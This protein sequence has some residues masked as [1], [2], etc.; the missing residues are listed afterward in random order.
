MGVSVHVQWKIGPK[1]A[2][3]VVKSRKF[4]PL[5]GQ[6]QSLN[7]TILLVLH[8]EFIF[9]S[10][11]YSCDWY[12]HRIFIRCAYQSR[13]RSICAIRP[14]RPTPTPRISPVRVT[15][16]RGPSRVIGSRGLS[17]RDT[18]RWPSPKIRP[19]WPSFF[20]PLVYTSKITSD[21]RY[22]WFCSLQKTQ[23]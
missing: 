15:T 2:Y 9:H 17:P 1:L 23:H 10:T 5:Y 11:V 6:S 4:L 16:S 22:T 20:R 18:S 3:C 19:R 13:I 8:Y 21:T 14:Q 7:T 12:A